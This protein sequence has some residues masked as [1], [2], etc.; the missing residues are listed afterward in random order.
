MV[1]H[2]AP[3]FHARMQRMLSLQHATWS[4]GR[5]QVHGLQEAQHTQHCSPCMPLSACI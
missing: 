3:V 1:P 2:P 4:R 5:S